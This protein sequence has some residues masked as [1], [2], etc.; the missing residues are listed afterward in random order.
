MPLKQYKATSPAR[1]FRQSASFDELTRGKAPERPLLTTKN[2]VSI[3]NL[4]ATIFTAMGISPQT[5]FDVEKRPFYATDDGKGRA[6]KDL[7]ARSIS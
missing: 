1:R 4:H 5:A 7:F 2:P 3:P 6:A